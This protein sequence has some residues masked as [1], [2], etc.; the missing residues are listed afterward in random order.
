MLL[1]VTPDIFHRVEFW[2]VSGKI[3]QVD[4]TIQAGHKVTYCPATMHRQPIPNDQQLGANMSL[5]M[6]QELDQLRRFDASGKQSEIEAP[7]GNSGDGRKALP[8]ERVL[9]HRSFATRSPGAHAVRPL[10]Q[11]ALV[12]KDYG[13]PLSLGFFFSSGQRTRFQRRIAGSSRCVALPVGRWQL[14]PKERRIRHT[15]PG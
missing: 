1:A 15:C 8:I 2:S 3:L 11:A 4:L 13:A 5:E 10:A 14:Q 12:H 6:F 7:D 9:Q